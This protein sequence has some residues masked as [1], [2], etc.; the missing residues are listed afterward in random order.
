MYARK[1]ELYV[2]DD[3]SNALDVETELELWKQVKKQFGKT[4]LI[5]SNSRYAI[6]I[7]DQIVLLENGKA[8]VYKSLEEAISKSSYMRL[9]VN[10]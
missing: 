10:T 2:L 4:F 9:L 8:Q 6:E 5:A 7:A 1:A 3:V